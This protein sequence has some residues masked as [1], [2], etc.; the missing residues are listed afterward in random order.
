[1]S[2][3]LQSLIRL[4][5]VDKDNI[6]VAASF[7]DD[8]A[9]YP[10]T[11][12]YV[13]RN[14]DWQVY[15]HRYSFTSLGAFENEK[16]VYFG[17]VRDDNEPNK[18][19]IINV[20]NGDLID[21]FDSTKISDRFE[22]GLAGYIYN[23]KFID[24]TIFAVGANGQFWL[25]SNSG[26]E[27]RTEL[28]QISDLQTKLT[29]LSMTQSITEAT[30]KF[31]EELV[32]SEARHFWSL[33][34]LSHDDVY[35]CGEWR[36]IGHW[37]GKTLSRVESRPRLRLHRVL[38][39]TRDRIWICGD[40]STLMLGNARDGFGYFEVPGEEKDFTA[41]T[42][43]QNKLVLLS[44]PNELHTFDNGRFGRL[45]PDIPI[46]D[47]MDIQAVDDVLWVMALKGLYRFDGTRW[48]QIDFPGQL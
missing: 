2:S 22:N 16:L 5:S 43:F 18:R 17:I 9:N 10:R 20:I 29:N 27:L 42:L 4:R 7:D 14:G 44:F 47:I 48:E 3:E 25:G 28:L 15:L 38:A 24:G 35:A 6:V 26:N 37:D 8:D 21:L 19:N 32:K 23:A 40:E 45:V 46:R 11:N 12:I 1:M 30:A 34:G 41:M 39:E 33:D 13:F 31:I 36:L